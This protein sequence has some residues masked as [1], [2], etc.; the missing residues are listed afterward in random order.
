LRNRVIA[1]PKFSGKSVTSFAASGHYL[2][3][4]AILCRAVSAKNARRASLRVRFT[5]EGAAWFFLDLSTRLEWAAW[6]SVEVAGARNDWM[7]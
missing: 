6:S 2:L 4:N 1:S 5:L 3:Q 7:R